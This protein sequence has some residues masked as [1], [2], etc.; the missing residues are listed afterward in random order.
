MLPVRM[1]VR[2]C[3]AE[4]G[5]AC[6]ACRARGLRRAAC[7]GG[8]RARTIPD[9]AH[10]AVDLLYHGRQLLVLL[11]GHGGQVEDDCMGGGGGVLVRRAGRM[12][13][14]AGCMAPCTAA[15]RCWRAASQS[16]CSLHAPITDPNPVSAATS[17][18]FTSSS[19]LSMPNVSPCGSCTSSSA[20]WKGKPGP[21]LSGG[22]RVAAICSS[23][24]GAGVEERPG[25]AGGVGSVRACATQGCHTHSFGS[26]GP[27]RPPRPCLLR[28]VGSRA[29]APRPPPQKQE[30][31]GLHLPGLL[32]GTVRCG[33]AC[34][35]QHAASMPT[36]A[37]GC[38]GSACA[39]WS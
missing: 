22:N 33:S 6:V 13:L 31:A 11:G 20:T 36:T 25:M 2:C 26:A 23:S 15:R 34:A 5:A 7:C 1:R 18:S 32:P 39:G 19:S 10:A 27:R 29:R 17:S 38:Q 37:G 12:G 9:A 30:D 28:A 3:R 14:A 35:T 8:H 16:S 21:N 4:L 24:M